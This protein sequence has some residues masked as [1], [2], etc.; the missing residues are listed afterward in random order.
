LKDDDGFILFESRAIGRYIASKSSNKSL[1]PTSDPKA[2]A[3]FEQGASIEVSNFDPYASGVAYQRVFHPMRGLKSDES[4][5][6]EATTTLAAKLEGYERIL[7]KQK[8]IAGDELTIAD[9]FH[10]SYGTMLEPQGI[11]LL[12]DESKYP[13]VAR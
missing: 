4:K 9:L 1:Y 6:T 5:V 11:T 8:Y 3:R 7:S 10:L 2:L 12:S 13:N